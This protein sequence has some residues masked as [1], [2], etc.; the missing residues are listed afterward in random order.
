MDQRGLGRLYW[1][2]FVL[3]CG[4]MVFLVGFAVAVLQVFP[5]SVIY[6]ALHQL[7]HWNDEHSIYQ[8]DQYVRAGSSSGGVV[9]DDPE[10]AYNGY[11]LFTSANFQGAF[12]I[13]MH[14][15]IVHRWHLPYSAIW[16]NSAAVKHPIDP[17]GI[18]WRDVYLYPDG[19]VLAVYEGWTGDQLW[20]YGLAKM[21]SNS[22]PIWTFLDHV[23][24]SVSVGADGRIYT[25]THRWHTEPLPA[26]PEILPPCTED[27]VVVLSPDGKLL[28]KVSIYD[29]F[30]K[31]QY[32]G[33]MGLLR[34]CI[35]G[36]TLH[37]NSV[38]P[39]P[40]GFI[41]NFPGAGPNTV[42]ISMRHLDAVAL[43]D[44]DA[45][46]IV[47]LMRG[48]W[49]RQ[50]DARPLPDGDIMLFDNVGDFSHDGHS[51]VLEFQ[52][53]PFRIVWDFP[54][55]T[56]E[57]LNTQILGAAQKLP[58]G[59]VLITDSGDAR[60]LEVTADRRVVWEYRSPFRAGSHR[61]FVAV[62]DSGQRFAPADLKF[63]LDQPQ[64]PRPSPATPR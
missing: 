11:T 8:T 46:K 52:P 41:R 62:L 18:G 59:N 23:H 55:D 5:Y 16:N 29:A 21:D 2:A 57:T 51:R 28:K 10:R 42:L 61:Q 33:V 63:P 13:D 12:L 44:L 64:S 19:D 38:K 7:H 54:G 1:A 35:V 32:R 26:F 4:F 36:D 58:N 9:R 6:P 48:P 25:L 47:W 45:Q 14:G 39:L 24:H 15:N 60:I 50:H 56:G 34:D 20:G 31:S 3:A 40:P 37:T 30:A 17:R 22:H 53:N 49:A 27:F 43:M